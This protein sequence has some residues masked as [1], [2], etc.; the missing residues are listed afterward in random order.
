MVL[1]E[2][3]CRKVR[4]ALDAH[5]WTQSDFA[6]ELGLSRQI[7]SQYVNGRKCPGL[8]VVERMAHCLRVPPWNLVDNE[9]LKFLAAKNCESPA[10]MGTCT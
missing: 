9:P 7:V 4:E 5:G 2:Q 6:R 10:T 1:R 8:G 3:F